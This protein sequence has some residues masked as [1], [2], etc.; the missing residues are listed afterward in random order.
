[1]DI[2]GTLKLI[3]AGFSAD[4]I[5]AMA[6]GKPEEPKPEDGSQGKTETK[7]EPGKDDSKH[8]GEV[9][10]DKHVEELNATIKELRE[11]IKSMQDNNI[12][13]AEGGNG[14]PAAKTHKEVVESFLN[15]F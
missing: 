1:M 15:K 2:E 9:S 10:K 6:N 8:A 14:D 5:R 12:K 3:E 4:E 11:T 7:E 13:N